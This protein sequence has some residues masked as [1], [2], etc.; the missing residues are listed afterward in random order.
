MQMRIGIFSAYYL[1]HLGGV[2]R[3]TSNLAREL[4]AANHS[5]T[6]ITSSHGGSCPQF[7]GIEVIEVPSISI[8]N[9]RFPLIIPGPAFWHALRKLSNNH[10][11]AI[12]INTRY[13]P[14]CLLGKK[15]ADDQRLNPIVIDHSSGYI[16]DD[17]GSMGK[18]MRLYER[19]ATRLIRRGSTR[20]FSV[21]Q[22]GV[23]WL[24]TFGIQA[25]GTLTNC[26]DAD[27][28]RSLSSEHDWREE[29]AISDAPLVVFAGRLIK[30]KGVLKVIQACKALVKQ[31]YKL[32]LVIA[33]SGP[34][35][36]KINEFTNE[37]I[38]FVGSLAQPDLSA[39]FKQADIFCLPTDYPEGLPTVLL[40]A[41]AHEC[42]II[43]SD[44]G[45]AEEVIPDPSYGIIL[46]DTDPR[47]ISGA[48]A[49]YLDHPAALK[50][51]GSRARSHVE[52]TL[53]WKKTME[54][55]IQ[56]LEDGC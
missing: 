10:F 12:V 39:L 3:Y 22:R 52:D 27:E 18:I 33:G 7:H 30:E 8:M 24:R 19:A 45:G 41:A 23:I 46:K 14:L 31:G 44:T 40:E 51:A 54:N 36:S 49:A 5:V 38:H 25:E 9:D 56:A 26:I 43:V 55:L 4:A 32:H 48:I 42:A 11:D 35:E 50:E 47:T 37:R 20:F 28:Y 34:L 16:S 6:V 17:P 21:S 15:I 13:Y 29:F 1:P 2:E 53:T